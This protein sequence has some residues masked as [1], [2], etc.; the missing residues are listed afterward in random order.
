MKKPKQ[1]RV[2]QE[3]I[4]GKVHDLRI[5]GD[6]DRVMEHLGD[7]RPAPEILQGILKNPNL[8]WGAK[9]ILM[10]CIVCGYPGQEELI[11]HGSGGVMAVRGYTKE[12][13]NAKY[14]Y[15]FWRKDEAGQMKWFTRIGVPEFVRGWLIRLFE[16]MITDE[17]NA[18][19][20][21]VFYDPDTDWHKIGQSRSLFGRMGAL[22]HK[23]PNGKPLFAIEVTDRHWAETYLH[24]M[25]KKDAK[26]GEW[27]DLSEEDVQAIQSVPW[28]QSPD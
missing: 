14:A 26:G 1:P 13:I 23:Y 27:F 24:N 5:F 2:V 12:L 9:G 11:S 4:D 3:V 25:F 21:Y 10:Y 8:S 28:L 18:G 20:V 16:T 17:Y 15:R 22:L 19:F 7:A 6:F